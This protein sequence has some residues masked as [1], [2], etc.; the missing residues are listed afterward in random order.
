MA[1]GD[2]TARKLFISQAGAAIASEVGRILEDA[3]HRVIRQQSDLANRGF[4]NDKNRL[5][6]LRVAECDPRGLRRRWPTGISR[7][8]APPQG[9]PRLALTM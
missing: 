2:E 3:G 1:S 4:F 5:I 6:V 9:R 7:A 8:L